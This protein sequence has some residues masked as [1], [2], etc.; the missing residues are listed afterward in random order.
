MPEANYVTA[1]WI[2]LSEREMRPVRELGYKRV[3]CAPLPYSL[4]MPGMS[5]VR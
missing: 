4:P 5:N 3:T 1:Y 2:E